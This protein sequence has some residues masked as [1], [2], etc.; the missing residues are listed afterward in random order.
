MDLP[1]TPW[2]RSRPA[3]YAALCAVPGVG[4]GV[5][6]LFHP[7]S[8]SYETSTMWY[9]LHVPGLLFFPLVGLALLAPVRGRTD[10]VSWVVRLT[11]YGYMTFYSALDVVSG[12]GAGYVTRELGPDEPRPPAVSLMFGIGTP[13]GEIGSWSLLACCVVLLA[14]QV[15]RLGAPALVGLLLL[16]GAWLVHVGHIFSPEGVAG[17]LLLAAGTAGLVYLGA[18]RATRVSNSTDNAT[19]EGS[20]ASS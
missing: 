9:G 14:D 7:H 11:A 20:R 4:L 5:A 10:A 18:A 13:L 16:P 17:M 8:L 2:L 19:N 12:I 15:R 3:A 1:R 6:G